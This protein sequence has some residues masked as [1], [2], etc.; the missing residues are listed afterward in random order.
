MTGDLEKEGIKIY[1]YD[2]WMKHF[3][4]PSESEW[5]I[6]PELTNLFVK[7]LLIY[8]TLTTVWT[9]GM[10]CSL[11]IFWS[12]FKTTAAFIL[13]NTSLLERIKFANVNSLH[14][15]RLLFLG[16]SFST[17][18]VVAKIGSEKILPGGCCLGHHSLG[19]VGRSRSFA[20]K[21]ASKDVGRASNDESN[22]SGSQEFTIPSY[23]T[24]KIYTNFQVCI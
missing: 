6:L 23:E 16:T 18:I 11:E 14:G 3:I 20:T 1:F 22:F 15:R 12:H 10:C 5:K 19:P 17:R 4:H 24:G 7:P 13:S 8:D 2:L 21:S 9:T